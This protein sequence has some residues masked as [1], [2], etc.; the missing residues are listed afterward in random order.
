MLTAKVEEE[1]KVEG[2]ATGD[3]DNDTRPFSVRDFRM[4]CYLHLKDFIEEIS[5]EAEKP[6]EQV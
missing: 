3:D 1:N 2:L 6:G 4:I 5:Q